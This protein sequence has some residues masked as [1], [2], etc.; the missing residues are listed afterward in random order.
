MKKFISVLLVIIMVLS[1]YSCLFDNKQGDDK[2]EDIFLTSIEENPSQYP[3]YHRLSAQEKEAYIKIYTATQNFEETTTVYR[4]DSEGDVRNFL[5]T[6]SYL[7]REIAYEHPEMFWYDPYN[8]ETT[9][10]INDNNEYLLHIKPHY[11]FEKQQAEQ[12]NRA[13][14]QKIE[15]IVTNAK[16]KANTYEQVLY[17]H[18]YIVANCV[19]DYDAYNRKDYTSPSINAYGCLVN[20][21]AICSG[22]TMA[23]STIMKQLG[24]EIGVEF[25][26]YSEVSLNREGHVWNYCNLD[27]DYYYFDLTWDD[28][29]PS[30]QNYKRFEYNHSY[31]GVTRDELA[32]AQLVLSP[33]SPTPQ[34]EGTK[35]NYFIY[36]NRNFQVYDFETVKSAILLQAGQKYIELRFDSYYELLR[37]ERDL[38]TEAKIFEIFPA[39]KSYEYYISSSNLQLYI[40]M[41]DYYLN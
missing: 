17:V 28:V 35:Y 13:F 16:T 10:G 25:R 27:G 6:F 21:K 22:Y 7:Y 36:N 20:G 18:D 12:M 41:N 3:L 29:D 5:Q 1:C 15:G 24:Y 23:F 34:C 40:F 38:L 32:T 30:D 4:G 11:L 31:F 39:A 19:Y 2:N 33:Q 9:I 8:F 26:S 37:A 14:Q